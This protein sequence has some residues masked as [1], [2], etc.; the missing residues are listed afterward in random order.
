MNPNF[1]HGSTG[2]KVFIYFGQMIASHFSSITTTNQKKVHNVQKMHRN[3]KSLFGCSPDLVAEIWYKIAPRGEESLKKGA[4]PR[5]LLWALLFMKV[6]ANDDTLCSLVG[7]VDSK[8]FCFWTRYFI[9]MMSRRLY[10]MEVCTA[11]L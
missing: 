4:E 7:G 8:T 6:Y 9:K 5:H 11:G 3:F 1:Q 2:P 10:N